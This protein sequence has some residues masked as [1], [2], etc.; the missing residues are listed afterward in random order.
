MNLDSGHNVTDN[1]IDLP[2]EAAGEKQAEEYKLAVKRKKSV[3]LRRYKTK[4]EMNIG[5]LLFALILIYLIITMITYATS[6]QIT[7]YE[8]RE[9]SI[10]KDNSYTGL[11]VREEMVVNAEADGYVSYFQS[12]TSKIKKGTNIYALSS[13]IIE[14]NTESDPDPAAEISSDTQK[15]LI[16]KIQ[17]F[18]ESYSPGKFSSVYSL[19]QEVST[20]IGTSSSASRS[21]FLGSVVA[22]GDGSIPVYQ[23]AR[24]GILVL[25]VDGYEEITE[26]T[27]KSDDFDRSNYEQLRLSD[28]MKV[29][30]GDPVYKL[31]TSEDWKIYIRLDK[32]TVEEL[33]ETLAFEEMNGTP[34]TA[35]VSIRIDK[36][37]EKISAVL[38]IIQKGDEYYGCFSCDNSMVRY[39]ADR[40][41]NVEMILEDETGLKIPKSAVV[42]KEFYTIPSDYLTTS[43][44][45]SSQGVMVQDG[46]EVKYQSAEVYYTAEDGIA[47]LDTSDFDSGTVLVKPDSVDSPEKYRMEKTSPLKGVYCVNQGYAVFKQIEILC[48]NDDYYIVQEGTS[49]GLNNYDHIVQDGTTINENEIVFQ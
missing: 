24:D 2:E 5:I 41:L 32:D 44:S 21:A 10:V 14:M 30:A 38:S 43:G 9:G 47:Y 48:E 36:D 16:L 42:E 33:Y 28:Q 19:K 1:Y 11:A 34:T 7:V 35:D 40:Y 18:N 3:S 8:V 31:V 17:N 45:S 6:K 49:Y 20:A 15:S 39:A 13:Q 23:S 25:M 26:D 37:S 4:Q 27:L 46:D 12:E 22:A 29:Q